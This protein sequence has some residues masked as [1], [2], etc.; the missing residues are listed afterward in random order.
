MAHEVGH[1]LGLFHTFQGYYSEAQGRAPLRLLQS[2]F[3]APESREAPPLV[4][5]L[6]GPLT[7]LDG[8]DDSVNEDPL[9]DTSP[10]D[11]FNVMHWQSEMEGFARL[12]NHDPDTHGN[13]L[14]LK[15]VGFNPEQRRILLGHPLVR[16]DEP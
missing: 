1:Y 7:P 5:D 2:A 10:R 14:A 6:H 12:E 11:L 9:V 8:T 16:T 3:E 13:P 4:N 15:G